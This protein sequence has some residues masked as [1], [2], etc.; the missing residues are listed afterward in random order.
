MGRGVVGR[1][2][3]L[4]AAAGRGGQALP[5]RPGAP[6]RRPEDATPAGADRGG[7]LAEDPDPRPAHPAIRC[8]RGTPRPGRRPGGGGLGA[9]PARVGC[10]GHGRLGV[11]VGG[12]RGGVPLDVAVRSDLDQF[13]SSGESNSSTPPSEIV[14]GADVETTAA[15]RRRWRRSPIEVLCRSPSIGRYL[16]SQ[17]KVARIGTNPTL[18]DTPR[19]P[20]KSAGL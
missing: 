14:I 6:L 13:G 2:D 4:P 10:P 15:W 1:R 5:R 17:A 7:R 18:S 9:A 20:G 19:R 12:G 8:G 16:V 11:A 3:A